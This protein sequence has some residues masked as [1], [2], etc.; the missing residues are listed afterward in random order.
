MKIWKNSIIILFVLGLVISC[1]SVSADT[2]T[3]STGDVFHWW[4]SGGAFTWEYD[5]SKPDI[6][7][8]QYSYD[9]SG[10]TLT[11]S[12]TVDGIINGGELYTYSLSLINDENGDTYM[13]TYV[14]GVAS[15][16]YLTQ[17]SGG[18]GDAVVSGNTLSC[19]FNTTSTDTSGY[20]FIGIAHQYTILNDVTAEYWVDSTEDLDDGSTSDDD[21]DDSTS[22]DSTNGDDSTSG[23]TSSPQSG[24]PGFEAIIFI[25]SLFFILFIKRKN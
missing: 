2:Q 19:T 6:D 7:I 18:M 24:T 21:D 20:E 4:Q 22:G 9:I 11:L 3:E 8:V 14:S 13:V 1:F 5:A 15:S 17:G 25:A 23:D 10:G 16:Y 12:L